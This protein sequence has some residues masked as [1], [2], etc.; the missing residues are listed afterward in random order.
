MLLGC[1][2]PKLENTLS[3]L[4]IG[5]IVTSEVNNIATDLQIALGLLLGDSKELISHFY[6]YRVTCSY[7]EILRFKKSAP[8]FSSQ[9]LC[10]QGITDAKS[11]LVQIVADN[12]D[13]D[14]ASLNCKTSTHSLAM[15]VMQ[16]DAT[17]CAKP[18]DT[19]K[20]LKKKTELSQPIEN[21]TPPFLV[22][23]GPKQ[24]PMAPQP[25]LFICEKLVQSETT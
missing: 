21:D 24:P 12:F 13:A 3:S 23:N 8:V 20:R 15:I 16:P 2:S 17:Q 19:I 18:I 7:D 5:N 4:L 14:I 6:D 11:G 25:E 1:L 9:D 10:K 22:Y